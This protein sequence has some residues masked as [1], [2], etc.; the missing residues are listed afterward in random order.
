[1]RPL[2]SHQGEPGRAGGWASLA[3]WAPAKVVRRREGEVWA[4]RA[5]DGEKGPSG[6]ASEASGDTWSGCS[7]LRGSSQEMTLH[8][9]P[10]GEPLFPLP[11]WCRVWIKRVHMCAPGSPRSDSL[12]KL[13][14]VGHHLWA[15]EAIRGC[16]GQ[17]SPVATSPVGTVGRQCSPHLGPG[18]W[19][20]GETCRQGNSSSSQPEA[21][22]RIELSAPRGRS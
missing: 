12:C 4:G 1:M 13:G 22:L 18:S 5:G 6:E 10:A 17:L 15:G 3:G 20:W 19:W 8:P 21:R 14:Q 11:Q 2:K 16:S 7:G 9:P